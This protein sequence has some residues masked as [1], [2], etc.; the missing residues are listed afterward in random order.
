MGKKFQC[1]QCD[2]VAHPSALKMHFDAVHLKLKPFK[3]EQCP[4]AYTQNSHLNNHFKEKH[5][6]YVGKVHQCKVC[7]N[8]FSSVS[9]LTKH[10]K[11]YH[12]DPDKI[13]QCDICKAIVSNASYLKKHKRNSHGKDNKRHKCEQCNYQC[14]EKGMMTAHIEMVHLKIRNFKCEICSHAF[15][16]KTAL[17]RHTKMVHEQVEKL[18]SC[19]QCEFQTNYERNL[20]GHK[21]RVHLGLRPYKCDTCEQTFKDLSARSAHK[22]RVHNV[23]NFTCEHCG[24]K[25]YELTKFNEHKA[26]QHQDGTLPE[27]KCDQCDWSTTFFAFMK[28]HK[29]RH[30]G[31]MYECPICRKKYI[32]KASM[33]KHHKI[34]HNEAKNKCSFCEQMFKDKG[35]MRVHVK[36]VHLELKNY[37]CEICDKTFSTSGIRGSHYKSAHRKGSFI[38]CEHCDKEF[39]YKSGLLKHMETNHDNKIYQCRRCD[40]KT[41]EH[42][43]LK[44]HQKENHFVCDHCGKRFGLKIQLINHVNSVHKG[45]RLTCHICKRTYTTPIG[46]KVHLRKMHYVTKNTENLKISSKSLKNKLEK[47][48]GPG[49]TNDLN[50]EDQMVIEGEDG[51][52]RVKIEPSDQLDGQDGL[53]S[54]S[55]QQTKDEFEENAKIKE[56]VK[57]KTETEEDDA[58]ILLTHPTEIS[59]ISNGSRE[60]SPMVNIEPSDE[61]DFL[62]KIEISDEPHEKENANEIEQ[63]TIKEKFSTNEV[64]QNV[65]SNHQLDPIY[66][67]K[68]EKVEKSQKQPMIATVKGE[69]IEDF[70]DHNDI[71]NKLSQSQSNSE[72]EREKYPDDLDDTNVN[73][74]TDDNV[75][76][77]ETD[78]DTE[79]NEFDNDVESN[80]TDDSV[81]IN[82]TNKFAEAVGKPAFTNESFVK[83]EIPEEP[84]AEMTKARNY[85][86]RSI[87]I[88]ATEI[89][90][91]KVDKDCNIRDEASID[92]GIVNEINQLNE[93]NLDKANT[94]LK[95]EMTHENS[96]TYEDTDSVKAESIETVNELDFMTN[97]K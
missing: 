69:E 42:S 17:Q 73:M 25:Y 74:E 5:G 77:N 27:F 22:R 81:E 3:C 52:P 23:K 58:T 79:S 10:H 54:E 85:P 93:E 31:K 29:E 26:R 32:N 94:I 80:E 9:T 89:K 36:S 61:L 67:E 34:I 71:D 49:E 4:M 28:T 11:D 66:Q 68:A 21:D 65:E 38:K 86:A 18:F 19:D 14:V 13:H 47:I 91:E 6:E 16:R 43:I 45:I 97:S 72:K 92:M 37:K 44:A 35:A 7:G 75:E 30:S 60:R 64:S 1:E 50:E 24:K 83:K 82:Q 55:P 8:K 39:M 84:V 12:E 40:F 87:D 76:S 53:A 78:D 62:V 41:K 33:Q 88:E 63:S 15:Y 95:M 2:Y 20:N 51:S 70:F 56:N 46:L 59:E 90:E 96:T 48:E 57:V